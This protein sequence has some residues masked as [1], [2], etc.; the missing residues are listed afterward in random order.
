MSL[1]F[2][3]WRSLE[4]NILPSHIAIFKFN[5]KHDLYFSNILWPSFVLGGNASFRFCPRASTFTFHVSNNIKNNYFHKIGKPSSIHTFSPLN[6]LGLFCIQLILKVS[7]FHL[8]QAS[9]KL[10]WHGCNKSYWEHDPLCKL[11]RRH[12]KHV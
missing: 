1:T 11:Y 2:V 6:L 3:A 8:K 7:K 10:L 12:Q 4:C 5:I 9:Q